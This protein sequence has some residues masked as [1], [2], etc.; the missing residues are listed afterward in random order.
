MH[1]VIDCR[2][3]HHSGIGR[4]IREIVPR[5]LRQMADHNFT[6]IVSREE[7]DETFMRQ[8]EAAHAAFCYVEAGMYSLREQWELPW[9]I[10]S[11]D[12]FW[13]VHYNAPLLPL[14]AKKRLV[15]IHD[16][17]HLAV[18][19][20]MS[21]AKRFYARLFFWNAAHRYD[22][23]FTDSKFSRQEILRHEKVPEEKVSV[24]YIAVDTERY[25]PCED[26]G[27]KAEVRHRY[28]LS[29]EY[30]LFVGN[31]KLN[32][33]LLRMLE[34]Y[35]AF[36]EED[37]DGIALAIVGKKEGLMTGVAEMEPLVRSLGVAE[38]VR[39]TGFVADEDLPVLYSAAKAFV[40]PS[41]Y[42]GFGLPPLEAMAC[43]CPVIASDAASLPEVCGDA[44]F[45]VNPYDI[46]DIAAGL[47][48]LAD[49]PELAADL[50]RRG[51]RQ[52]G[53]FS[54]EE[55]ASSIAMMI[56]QVSR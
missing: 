53:R 38:D 37:R 42:E 44:A 10:P 43:G 31:V 27:R 3:V 30:F 56:G 7:C 22:H 5:I 8:C 47:H 33:N 9:R 11:C 28:G 32:K 45:Y 21:F 19:D 12:V 46:H 49:H 51:F 52:V 48:E 17:A 6:L 25:C 26:E 39:F 23:V 1:I 13:A 41:L 4:Y 2:F 15:T 36:H 16:M 14:R 35:A 20:G 34:A 29:Q 54:W 55:A 18:Q 50:V 40:F 24:H